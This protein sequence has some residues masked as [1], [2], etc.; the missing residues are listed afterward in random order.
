MVWDFIDDFE[1]IDGTNIWVYDA[2]YL[3]LNPLSTLKIQSD[4]IFNLLHSYKVNNLDYVTIA[5]RNIPLRTS[6]YFLIAIRMDTANESCTRFNVNNLNGT[7]LGCMVGMCQ[8]NGLFGNANAIYYYNGIT[9]T[10]SGLRW[11]INTWYEFTM[12]FDCAT[13][14]FSCS[15]NGG[16][17]SNAIV[18][19]NANYYNAVA[20]IGNFYMVTI[21]NSG[22]QNFN[23]WFDYVRYGIPPITA[24]INPYGHW[25]Y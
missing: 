18:C 16:I 11:V 12:S 6:G 24:S 14:K 4:Q 5:Y 23:A 20:Q 21:S 17:H 25:R 8:Q 3:H 2:N 19:T 9:M 10:D 15:V 7:I 22:P 1:G 13:Q